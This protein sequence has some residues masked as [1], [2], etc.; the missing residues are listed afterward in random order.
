[1]AKCGG[2]MKITNRSL[3]RDVKKKLNQRNQSIQNLQTDKLK[4]KKLPMSKHPKFAKYVAKWAEDGYVS[5]E[6][7][8][9]YETKIETN[10]DITMES[11]SD[12]D[13]ESSTN[14]NINSNIS[15]KNIL[16]SRSTFSN[17]FSYGK[18]LRK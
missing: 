7:S 17:N 16:G 18:L 11:I 4:T 1:M 12:G 3:E 14:G 2:H 13:F 5:D 10:L 6:E 9:E 15:R 8:K